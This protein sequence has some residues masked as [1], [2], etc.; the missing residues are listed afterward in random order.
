M[1]E[2]YFSL[3]RIC[4]HLPSEACSHG[5]DPD[6]SSA[7]ASAGPVHL[8]AGPA[9][10]PLRAAAPLRLFAHLRDPDA[11]RGDSLSPPE[12]PAAFATTRH[13]PVQQRHSAP[14]G[15]RG[16]RHQGRDSQTPRHPQGGGLPRQECSHTRGKWG[17]RQKHAEL[18][19]G[20]E[21]PRPP[22]GPGLQGSGASAARVEGPQ[23]QRLLFRKCEMAERETLLP[24]AVFG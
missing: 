23:V 11:D 19:P 12:P 2:A 20:A 24:G 3:F 1:N 13:R 15:P 9:G 8:Q 16:R 18:R 4:T 21:G 14:H 7:G 5:H 22:R 10:A 17:H 6:P